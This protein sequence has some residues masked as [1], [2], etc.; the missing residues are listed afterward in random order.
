MCLS[1]MYREKSEEDFSVNEES[2]N[3]IENEEL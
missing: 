2:I 3:M 1:C